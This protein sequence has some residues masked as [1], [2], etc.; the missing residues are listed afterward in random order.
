MYGQKKIVI[1]GMYDKCNDKKISD[2]PGDKK[3]LRWRLGS[4]EE[5]RKTSK[6]R[7]LN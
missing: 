2:A 6:R 3:G 5:C 4:W 1:T 7:Y